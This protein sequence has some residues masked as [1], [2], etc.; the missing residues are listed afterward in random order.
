MDLGIEGENIKYWV[1]ESK[2]GFPK[3][4]YE[5]NVVVGRKKG[6]SRF[7]RPIDEYFAGKCRL[8]QGFAEE[9]VAHLFKISVPQL[10]EC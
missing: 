6:R 3:D 8:K 7:L 9:R 10:V 4:F 5:E 2:S 1:S